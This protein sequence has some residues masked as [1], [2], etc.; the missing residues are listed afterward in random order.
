M[1]VGPESDFDNRS[2]K[3]IKVA[4][5]FVNVC[6]RGFLYL[7]HPRKINYKYWYLV[8]ADRGIMGQRCV[9]KGALVK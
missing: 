8:G 3:N 6:N 7:V 9:W 1:E 5:R 4:N 2:I